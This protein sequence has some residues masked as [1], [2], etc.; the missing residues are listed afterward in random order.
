LAAY[1]K[2]AKRLKAHLVFIDESGFQLV[3][4]IA[5]TWA[6]RGQTPLLRC[7][8]RWT[9]IS[10]IS[11]ISVSPLR[12]KISLY[13]RFLK[14]KTIHS[15]DVARFLKQLL[16]HL[17]GPVFVLWDGINQHRG[18]AVRAFLKRHQ[19]LLVHRFP[20]YAPDLNPDEFVWNHLKRALAN[21]A[22]EDLKHL[23]RLIHTP[24]QR[25][26]QNKKLLWSCIHASELP[27]S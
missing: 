6:P 17:R 22:P 27:W 4:S 21:S 1:K 11:A 20:G 26:R 19:R 2:K 5:R 12:N 25:L 8:V 7:A 10:A 13:A 9:K 15:E 16:K 3:P 23:K 18:P 24:L 14:G